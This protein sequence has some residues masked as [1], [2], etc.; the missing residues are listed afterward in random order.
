M[1]VHYVT[2]SWWD[3]PPA[4]HNDGTTVSW[5]D[6]HGSYLQWKAVETIEYGRTYQDYCGFGLTPQTPE[7]HKK[8]CRIC[9]RAVWGRLGY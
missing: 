8:T 9:Q 6:G 4:R 1:R 7:G 5:A 3:D 2:P